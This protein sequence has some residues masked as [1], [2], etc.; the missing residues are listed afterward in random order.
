M[1]M[2][3]KIALALAALAVVATAGVTA[4][5]FMSDPADAAN[6]NNRY[7]HW[8]PA[9]RFYTGPAYGSCYVRRVIPTAFGPRVEWVNVCW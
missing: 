2:F 7:H 8:R 9:V 3:R 5:T 6:F 1:T 4:T